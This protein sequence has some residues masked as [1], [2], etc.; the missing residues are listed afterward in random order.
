MADVWEIIRIAVVASVLLGA[1][2]IFLL[3]LVRRLATM[4]RRLN[5]LHA[6]VERLETRASAFER[7]T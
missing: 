3:Y 2:P 7:V 5:D 4:S 1:V 6:R